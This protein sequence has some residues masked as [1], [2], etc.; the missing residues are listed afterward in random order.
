MTGKTTCIVW[1]Q[2]PAFPGNES[3]TLPLPGDGQALFDGA[4]P[5]SE[6]DMAL[7]LPHQ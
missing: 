2:V 7:S 4:M 1:M 3:F 5:A 6:A